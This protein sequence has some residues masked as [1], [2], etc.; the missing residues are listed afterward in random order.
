[1]TGPPYDPE[2]R[3]IFVHIW[4]CGGHSF[5]DILRWQFGD[6]LYILRGSQERELVANLIE[7]DHSQVRAVHGHMPVGLANYLDGPS[8]YMI[9]LRHPVARVVSEYHFAKI[10]KLNGFHEA[11]NSGMSLT[12]FARQTADNAMV[13]F[14][15]ARPMLGDWFPN[16]AMTYRHLNSAMCNLA[17]FAFA[18]TVETYEQDVERLKR[19]TGW[20]IERPPHT[21]KTP[22]YPPPSEAEA[23][24]IAQINALDLELYE[25][26]REHVMR[27]GTK[28]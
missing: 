26:A 27:E 23:A 17:S 6:G 1:M 24:E 2:S 21:N 9:M 12:E 22:D 25:W 11:V 16:D 14:L 15:Q 5:R 4:K 20:T 8:V 19:L 3:V 28:R 7:S 13:R 10:E 18:G